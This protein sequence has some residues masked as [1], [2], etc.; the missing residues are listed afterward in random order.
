MIADVLNVEAAEI[1]KTLELM[2]CG[3][4][5]Q[6]PFPL[7]STGMPLEPRGLVTE[8]HEASGTFV[9][10]EICFLGVFYLPLVSFEAYNAKH[11][12]HLGHQE[13]LQ[14]ILPCL[15]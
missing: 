6:P 13:R 11:F 14:H 5:D 2:Q 3:A 4:Q 12:D 9:C 10:E 8:C 15:P 7:D 1:M